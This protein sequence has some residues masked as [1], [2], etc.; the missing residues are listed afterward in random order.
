MKPTAQGRPWY[1]C[2]AILVPFALAL[3][4]LLLLLLLLFVLLLLLLLLAVFVWLCGAEDRED[5][6]E[7]RSH[8]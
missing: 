2:P 1:R 3:P 8:V 5:W 6:R 4:L 7:E